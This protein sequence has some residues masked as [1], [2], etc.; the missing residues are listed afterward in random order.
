[1]LFG[2]IVTSTYLCSLPLYLFVEAPACN[3][4]KLLLTPKKRPSKESPETMGKVNPGLSTST[5]SVN[6]VSTH[7]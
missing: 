7:I 4:Q 5:V 2:G 6:T 3:L 1:M